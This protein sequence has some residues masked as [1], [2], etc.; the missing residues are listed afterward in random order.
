MTNQQLVDFIFKGGPGSGR[1]PAGSG[2]H[3]QTVEGE[4][5]PAFEHAVGGGLKITATKS[6]AWNGKQV[7]IKTQLSKQETGRIGEA[8]VLA[9]LHGQGLK[10]AR[11]LNEKQS[12]FPVDMVQDHGAIE[13]K[14]GLVSNSSAAQQW[15]ATIGQP[16]KSETQWLKTADP[17]EKAAW[18]QKKMQAILDRKEAA[19]KELSKDLGR[20]VKGYTMTT[21]INPDTKTVDIYKFPGFHLRIPWNHPS[22]AKAYVGSYKYK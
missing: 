22:V 18:N 1:Y 5:S 14:T 15:R 19:V 11:P 3:P 2:E 17:K 21:H 16:G 12:N 9:H 6:R 20:A 7:E 4:V 13:V 8:A 10:D